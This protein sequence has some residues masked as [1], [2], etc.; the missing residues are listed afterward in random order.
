MEEQL[1]QKAQSHQ[2]LMN[3]IQE[4]KKEL[5]KQAAKDLNG[6]HIP[7]DENSAENKQVDFICTP[8]KDRLHN[9]LQTE[10]L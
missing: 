3:R 8:K 10:V 5:K 6:H 1:K 2:K 7:A 9:Q 4:M